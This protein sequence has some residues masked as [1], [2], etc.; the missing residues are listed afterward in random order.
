MDDGV[1]LETT[2]Y[3]P[4]GTPPEA[5]W[6]G[7]VML[8]GLG[9]DRRR[10]NA[11]AEGFFAAHGYAVLTYDAR[12]HFQ[13]DGLVTLAGPREIADVRALTAMFAARP[14]VDDTH[15]GAFGFSY[16]GGQTWL[17]AAAGVPFAAIVTVEAWTDLYA[18]LIPGNLPKSGIIGGF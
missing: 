4:D 16:G 17:A 3:L 10:M 13:S 7:I 12:G 2:L 6:P 15:I 11:L 1:E 18:A 9:S 5:G 8:H 14:D